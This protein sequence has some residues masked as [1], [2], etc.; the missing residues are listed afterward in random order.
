MLWSVGCDLGTPQFY[1]PLTGHRPCRRRLLIQAWVSSLVGGLCWK[2]RSAPHTA[3]V[4]WSVQTESRI[5]P[6]SPLVKYRYLGLSWGE[7]WG[8]TGSAVPSL[9][10]EWLN[11]PAR[12]QCCAQALRSTRV[13]RKPFTLSGKCPPRPQCL[14]HS[15]PHRE[16][17]TGAKPSPEQKTHFPHVVP[18]TA[19]VLVQA[20]VWEPWKVWSSPFPEATGIRDIGTGAKARAS[21]NTEGHTPGGCSVGAL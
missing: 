1:S 17:K 2:R 9:C 7:S 4:L 13:H 10:S 18:D 19:T 14:A 16:E 6:Y 15:L 11:T 12:P 5:L 3:S 8:P 20:L 21:R